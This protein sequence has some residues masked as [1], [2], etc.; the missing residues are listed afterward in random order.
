MLSETALGV[1]LL[2]QMRNHRRDARSSIPENAFY[3]QSYTIP[4]AL[5]IGY[6]RPAK[7][8]R[9]G[10]KR[11]LLAPISASKINFDFRRADLLGCHCQTKCGGKWH[12]LPL[13]TH[14]TFES[15]I[16]I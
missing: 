16:N 3:V 2:W 7:I 5:A 8:L 1:N 14:H 4:K 11:H 15:F 6:A 12:L 13:Q 10:S 9:I